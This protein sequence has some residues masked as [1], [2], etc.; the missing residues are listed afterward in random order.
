MQANQLAS[1]LAV[2]CTAGTMFFSAMGITAQRDFFLLLGNV[3]CIFGNGIFIFAL[4]MGNP[5]W[6]T[7][8]AMLT[9]LSMYATYRLYKKYQRFG[10][11]DDDDE[12]VVEADGEAEAQLDEKERRAAIAEMREAAGVSGDAPAGLK[13]DG[14]RRRKSRA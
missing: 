12:E 1:I 2:A 8:F 4:G 5:T 11:D 6:Q 14:I 13:T 3:A 9:V 7:Y 10:C